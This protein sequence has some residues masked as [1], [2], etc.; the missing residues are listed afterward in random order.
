MA[1]ITEEAKAM[2]AEVMVRASELVSAL[3]ALEAP[4]KGK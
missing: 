3:P 4:K 2:K 1:E